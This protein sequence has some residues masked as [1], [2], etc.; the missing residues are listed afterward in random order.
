MCTELIG[1]VKVVYK[2]ELYREGN[3]KRRVLRTILE[4]VLRE[5]NQSI[6]TMEAIV[7]DG[8][9]E[10]VR[11]RAKTTIANLSERRFNLVNYIKRL[12]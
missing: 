4:Q 1:R 8:K 11:E 10:E 7:S 3:L 9:S 12:D 5:Y 2:D 6:I